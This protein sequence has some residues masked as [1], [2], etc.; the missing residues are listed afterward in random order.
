M[1]GPFSW[2]PSATFF[3]EIWFP[4]LELNRFMAA[5]EEV[6]AGVRH[7]SESP[8]GASLFCCLRKEKLSKQRDQR[9]ESLP[10]NVA[11]LKY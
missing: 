4:G 9:E 8:Q 7:I 10:L 2:A 6:L 11:E 1:Q 3:V 5:G